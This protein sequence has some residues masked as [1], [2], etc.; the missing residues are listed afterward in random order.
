MRS[1][2]SDTTAGEHARQPRLRRRLTTL[3]PTAALVL[4]LT[5]ITDPQAEAATGCTASYATQS[6][7][8]GGLVGSVTVT[9]TG[10]T[11]IT[12]WTVTFVFGGD[13]KVTSAWGATVTQS[14]EYVTASNVSYDGSLGVGSGTSFGFQ[15]TWGSSD[16]VPASL[17]CTP[18]S[19]VTP[20]IVTNTTSAPVMQGF[21]DSVGVALSAAPT[22]NVNVA[23]ARTSGNS[24][25]TVATGST[26][27]T[28]TPTNWN[29]AQNVTIAADSA[30]TGAATFGL[31]STGYAPAAVTLTEVASSPVPQLHVSGN[32]LVDAS[33]TQVVLHGVNRSGAEYACVQGW[34]FFDGP[35]DE[36]SIQSIKSW[37][38]ITAVRVPLNEACWNAESYV[39]TAYAGTNYISA[40]KNYVNLLNANGIVVILDLHWTDGLYTGTSSGCSSAQATCQKP[41]PDAAQAIPFWTSV[42]NTFKGDNAVVFDL[43][44]EPY[45]S[46]ATGDTTTGWQ[47]WLNG[48]ACAGI[49][50]PVAG[51]QGM[52][53]AVRSLIVGAGSDVGLALIWSG[54]LLVCFVPLAVRLY[55]SA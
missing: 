23:V 35:V 13:Q 17:T 54:A 52:V 20:A 51:M 8:S 42:A 19:T 11:A 31:S 3:I 29:T 16:K 1:P 37:T 44:N 38:H 14:I 25:L 24:G 48:G 10:T 7:W 32:K 45:A 27:L 9:N 55:R 47:C 53:N 41:M 28:F 26:T 6:E 39:N 40:V 2:F 12:G 34:G 50:Y 15:G 46:R 4:G 21:T 33:G 18:S 5:V 22:A 36:A 43:F 30:G 49:S